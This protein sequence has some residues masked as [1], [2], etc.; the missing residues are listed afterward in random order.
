MSDQYFIY[1]RASGQRIPVSKKVFD[2]YY[3]DI[4][5]YRRRQMRHGMCVCPSCAWLACDMDCF[6]CP[7]RR[8]G[9]ERS[10]DAT[11]CNEK[12][13][14]RAMLDTLMDPK[15]SLERVVVESIVLKQLLARIEELMPQALEVAALREEG[16]S[17]STIAEQLGIP[18]KTLDDRLKKLR[19]IVQKEFPEIF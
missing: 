10:L 12:G 4:N 14:E 5:A 7:Y 2:D 11:E 8:A 17:L 3:R 13:D 18:R 1:L 15:A 16:M 9:D 6:T 19:S